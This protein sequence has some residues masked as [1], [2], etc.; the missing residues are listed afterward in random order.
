MNLFGR[1]GTTLNSTALSLVFAFAIFCTPALYARQSDPAGT[2]EASA[3]VATLV[4]AEANEETGSSQAASGG[5]VSENPPQ[6]PAKHLQPG[7][8]ASPAPDRLT[9]HDRLQ[10]Y[11]QSLLSPESLIGPLVGAGLSQWRDVPP[12][13]GKGASGFGRRFASAEG[14]NVIGRTIALGVTTIDHE[15]S[16]YRRS[17]ETDFF[18]R[19]G[20]AMAS[21]FVSHTESGGQMPAFGRLVGDYS[22]GFIANVWEPTSQQG[23][24]H[25][26][27]RGSTSLLSNLIGN[28]ARE[29]WPDI[30]HHRQAEEQ[31]NR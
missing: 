24:V 2:P 21:T 29:F 10:I 14:R 19:A 18:K 9:F 12:E 13:W 11:K 4:A 25:A 30:F 15:D 16:R 22:A 17:T 20:H 27:E 7:T 8:L 23:A 5:T 1:P 28:F 26:I 3:A 6:P 31:R